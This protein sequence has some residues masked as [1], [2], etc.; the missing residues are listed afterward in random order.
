MD[1]F[2]VGTALLGFSTR[3]DGDLG[4]YKM[5]D[6]SAIQKW[7]SL[8]QAQSWHFS[9]PRFVKQVHGTKVFFLEGPSSAGLQGEADAI[10]TNEDESPV[11]VFSADC[12]PVIVVGRQAIAAIHAGWKSS[13]GNITGITIEQ[14]CSRWEEGICDLSVFL[15]PCIGP[16][17]L[18]MGDEIPIAF[19]DIASGYLGAFSH[20]KKWHLDLRA[21]NVM[22]ALESGVSL[23]N[24]RHVNDCTKCRVDKYF[25]FRNS[26]QRDGSMFSFVVRSSKLSS[27]G[28]V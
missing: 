16:C 21:L 22:Q 13:L 2:E 28:G 17:C 1:F 6:R 8:C 12:L 24:I 14:F 9:F 10:S 11:G 18:E 27:Q 19:S 4:F 5:H 7:A 3:Q 15:G 26:P 23:A 20:G 25:S